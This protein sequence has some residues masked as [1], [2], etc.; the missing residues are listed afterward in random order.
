[1]I[2][3]KTADVALHGGPVRNR[4]FLR[5]KESSRRKGGLGKEAQPAPQPHPSRHGH[6]GRQGLPCG[7]GSGMASAPA[8]ALGGS[9]RASERGGRAS[10]CGS[11]VRNDRPLKPGRRARPRRQRTEEQG[12]GCRVLPPS[13]PFARNA[14]AQNSIGARRGYGSS[15]RVRGRMV[16]SIGRRRFVR[17]SRS[18]GGPAPDSDPLS[19]RRRRHIGHSAKLGIPAGMFGALRGV[20]A[21][22][23]SIRTEACR[24]GI[25]ISLQ[26]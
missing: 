2:S 10:F 9:A 16:R 7:G 26:R 8:S 19:H 22:V 14:H 12:C 5:T 13:S 1:M 3:R 20:C 17:A 21:V 15:V 6:R 11:F 25:G 18:R 24:A 4:S 23:P